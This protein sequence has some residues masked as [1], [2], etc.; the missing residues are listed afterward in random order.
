MPV[1]VGAP[2]SGTTL[3]RLMLDSHPD[4][5]IPPETGFL[6]AAR[7]LRGS[8]D[9]LRE[10][11]FQ[12]VTAF[13]PG[14]SAWADFG[15]AADEFRQALQQIEPFTASAGFRAFYRLYAARHGKP[16]WGDKTPI[17]CLSINPIR[18]LLPEA[19][20]V[21]IIRDGRDVAL[22]LREQWFSPGRD[23]TTLAKYWARCVAGARKAGVGRSDYLEVRYEE[24]VRE[25]ARVLT[26][27]CQFLE[28]DWNPAV[29]AHHTRAEARLGEHT[30]RTAPDG[31]E[32][33]SREQRLRQQES[34]LRAPDPGRIGGWRAAMRPAE[35]AEFERVAGKLLGEL[36]Y[37]DARAAGGDPGTPHW[38]PT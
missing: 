17:Y 25:P 12:T 15:I 13:P 6:S 33:M 19:R 24:L 7:R 4:L 26:R 23:M 34:A 38:I 22:S 2:R 9:R 35:R 3:L 8:G 20:F 16:R 29:L 18:R 11:F 1:V 5:A 14:A 36:G 30:G 32:L 10:R 28:L 21:H 31:T 37:L 27:T